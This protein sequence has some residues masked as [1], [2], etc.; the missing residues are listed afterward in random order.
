MWYFLY[1]LFLT[2]AIAFV[3]PLTPFI[4]LLG[5]RYRDG[6]KQRL[7]FYPKAILS[8]LASARPVWIHAAS[9]GEVRS[10]EPLVRELKARAPQRKILISTFTST[11]NRV[12]QRIGGV[13]A[14]IFLPLDLLWVVRRALTSFHPAVL[15]IIETEIWPNLLREAFRRG[16][17]T[18]LLSGRLSA[19]A[20]LRYSFCRPFFRLVLDCF[21][22]LG[23]QSAADAARIRILGATKRKV[24]VVGSL[25]FASQNIVERRGSAAAA[26][27]QG[28]PLL[29]A[30]SSH[31]G[32]EEILLKAFTLARSWFPTLSMILAPRHPE[33]F[34]EV[35]KLLIDSPFDFQRKSQVNGGQ[36]FEK[37]VLLL[38]T[39]GELT[40][41]FAAADIA[42]VG[43]SLVDAGGHN[44]LEP[45]RYHK[46]ILFGPN[47]SNFK[48]VAEQMK[49]KGAAIEVG[50]ADDL[51]QALVNLLRD[52]EKRRCMGEMAFQIAGAN[53][54][55]LAQNL[56]LAERYL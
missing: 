33:R 53:N 15:M 41:F 24:S 14:V 54:Q 16:V 4:F 51:A 37:D 45:A 31:R 42:F 3:L 47:M 20:F 18:L 44:V 52:S 21:T 32:E 50:G 56:L 35:E 49:Q 34:A 6:Y 27:C 23:M 40:E 46:P 30:G 17:P 9:V 28:K 13:D 2:G 7:G 12:A 8:S 11:G 22:V 29:V 5:A 43:G 36:F 48:D 39:V 1:N 25:K 26:G 19:K 55:A 10:A 38:D